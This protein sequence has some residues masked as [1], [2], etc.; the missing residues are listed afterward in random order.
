MTPR[1][2]ICYNLKMENYIEQGSER[3]PTKEE[4]L[5]I[6]GRHAER[7]KLKQELFDENGPYLIEAEGEKAGETVEYQYIRKGEFPSGYA[8]SGTTINVLYFDFDK[9]GTP[10]TSD[11]IAIYNHQTGEWQDV[12]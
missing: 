6:I 2:Y 10:C 8:S 9:E 12:E 7:Y 3:I 11:T 1:G 4:V 5:D